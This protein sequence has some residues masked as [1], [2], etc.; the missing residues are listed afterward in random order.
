MNSFI[1]TATFCLREGGPSG[2][3]FCLPRSFQATK[4]CCRQVGALFCNVAS[5]W[6]NK[7][8][9]GVRIR[10][11]HAGVGKCDNSKYLAYICEYRIMRQYADMRID[12]HRKKVAH[13]NPMSGWYETE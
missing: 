2:P 9:V 3:K 7:D 6:I 8:I 5:E 13:G 1:M 4:V 12:A 10:D 11:G